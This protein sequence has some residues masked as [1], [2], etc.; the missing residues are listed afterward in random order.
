MDQ[1][2]QVES[3]DHANVIGISEMCKYETYT[4]RVNTPNKGQEKKKKISG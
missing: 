2:I 3:L 1:I 4:Y